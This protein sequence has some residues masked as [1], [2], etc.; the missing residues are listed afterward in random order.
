VVRLGRGYPVTRIVGPHKTPGVVAFD[1][2]NGAATPFGGAASYTYS[3]T[4]AAG[5]LIVADVVHSNNTTCTV[6]YGGTSMTAHASVACNNVST[7]GWVRRFTLT[8]APGGA[9]TVSITFGTSS[10]GQACTTSYKSA[11]SFGTAVTAFA[12]STAPSQST[13]IGGYGSMIVQCWGLSS[14]GNPAWTS[15]SGGTNRYNGGNTGGVCLAVGT[16]TAN[17]TFTA[18]TGTAAPEAAIYTVLNP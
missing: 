11:N 9:Q 12:N 16:A 2:V 8:N 15:T 17:T 7:N 18:N 6:T 4:A 10:F 13:T 3:N 14:S 5:S 1:A